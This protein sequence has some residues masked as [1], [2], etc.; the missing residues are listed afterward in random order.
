VKA[1]SGGAEEVEDIHVTGEESLSLSLL[2][3][4]FLILWSVYASCR[5]D[6]AVAETS[7]NACKG[8]LFCIGGERP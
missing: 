3:S 1:P 8:I 6:P 5:G 4:M 7:R 2:W